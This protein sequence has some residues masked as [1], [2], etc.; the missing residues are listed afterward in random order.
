MHSVGHAIYL[1]RANRGLTQTAVAGLSGVSRPN[2]SAIEQGARDITIQTLR[3]IASALGASPGA[4]VDGIGP[5][6]SSHFHEKHD[7]YSLDRIAR[8][9]A[10]Q[11]L[12]TSREERR[13]AGDLTSIMKSKTRLASKKNIPSSIR[14]GDA[15][16]L[17]LKTD[18]GPDVLEHLIR[19]VEKNLA[20]RHE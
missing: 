1:W 3:R 9:A 5:E 17:R 12:K 14:A 18:L 13:I 8:R 10:G 6:T 19:R 4:L 15:A 11:S 7:R 20:G 2:L 16:L